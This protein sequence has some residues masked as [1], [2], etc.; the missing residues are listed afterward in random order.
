MECSAGQVGGKIISGSNVGLWM[1]SKSRKLLLAEVLLTLGRYCQGHQDQHHQ[2][3]TPL[4]ISQSRF[5]RAS[6][7]PL[8][9][10]GHIVAIS[11]LSI[12]RLTLHSA[13]PNSSH[14][15]LSPHVRPYP[16]TLPA[17][18]C[19]LSLVLKYVI[20]SKHGLSSYKRDGHPPIQNSKGE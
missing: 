20:W 19:P 15:A 12:I 4:C 5:R 16:F 17:S 10:R 2:T 1:T 8:G 3:Y 9:H 18:S 7:P 11:I 13:S 14:T 6:I